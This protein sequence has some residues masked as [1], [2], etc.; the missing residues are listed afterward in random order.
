M[1]LTS[2]LLLLVGGGLLYGA[3]MGSYTGLWEGRPTQLLYSA[4]KV[5]L[6][7]FLSF[8]VAL[9]SF[10]ALNTLLGL[11]DDLPAVLRGIVSAQTALTLVLAS[12]APLTLTFYAASDDYP[13]AILWNGGMFLIATLAGQGVLRRAYRPLIARDAK[14]RL[15]FWT[16][17]T[18]YAFVGIQAAWVLR[19]FIGDPGRPVTFFREGAWGNAYVEIVHIASRAFGS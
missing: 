7:L 5:P 12:L 13:V 18:L 15:M 17:G 4:L 1:P 11:R 14:H 8:A 9:P 16:W 6:L 19:P 10:F 3:T 2:L